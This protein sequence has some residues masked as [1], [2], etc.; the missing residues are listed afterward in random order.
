MIARTFANSWRQGMRA[1]TLFVELAKAR[2]WR[3]QHASAQQDM[4]QHWD[5]EIARDEVRMRLDV[6]AMKRQARGDARVQDTWTWLELRGVNVGN[7][8]WLYGGQSDLIAFQTCTD[9]LLVRRLALIDLVEKLVDP[10][11]PRVQ[12]AREAHYR[13]YSRAG[14]HDLITMV[15]T[16]RVREISE[17]VWEYEVARTSEE[18]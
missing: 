4:H 2:G 1:E 10:E 11:L 12:Y 9:F 16:E 5:F 3:V 15:E 17:E 13:V 14:R 7:S 6:K 18:R 8:G